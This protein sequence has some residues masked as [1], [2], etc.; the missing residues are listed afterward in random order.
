M[1]ISALFKETAFHEKTNESVEGIILIVDDD[2]GDVL[3]ELLESGH[4][5]ALIIL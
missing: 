5:V 2:F 1:N 4:E 3:V